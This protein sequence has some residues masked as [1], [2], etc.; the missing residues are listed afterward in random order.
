MSAFVHLVADRI[1]VVTVTLPR[2][3]LSFPHVL[4]CFVTSISLMM[5]PMIEEN[6]HSTRSPPFRNFRQFAMTAGKRAHSPDGSHGDRPAKR[7]LLATGDVNIGYRHFSTSF[8][9]GSRYPPEDWVQQAGGL[10]INSPIFSLTANHSSLQVPD[11]EMS[12]DPDESGVSLPRT[13]A[14][15]LVSQHQ[16]TQPPN[17]LDPRYSGKMQPVSD[18]V[19]PTPISTVPLSKNESE[20]R[21][22]SIQAST[23]IDSSPDAMVLSSPVTSFSQISSPSIKRRVFFGPRIGCEKCRLGVKGHFIHSE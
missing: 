18:V 4:R 1:E 12:V 3:H 9:N 11:V 7:V 8:I 6:S 19:S 21:H 15:P 13:L 2:R 17:I 16:H 23:P 14:P 20:E 5:I 22:P 10:T